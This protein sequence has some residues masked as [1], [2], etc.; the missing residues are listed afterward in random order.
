MEKEISRT[1][2]SPETELHT[3]EQM[4]SYKVQRE[5]SGEMTVFSINGAGT[6]YSFHIQK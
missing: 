5:S 3:C 2:Q 6:H 1:E 4:I